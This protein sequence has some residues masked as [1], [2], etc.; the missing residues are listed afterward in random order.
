[1][2]HITITGDLGSGKSAVSRLLAQQLGCTVISTGAIQRTIAA[3]HGMTTLELNKYTET[4]PEIDDLIDSRIK[5]LADS[6][7]LYVIDSRLAWFFLPDSFKVY[8]TVHAEVAVERVLGDAARKQTEAY[9]SRTA[10]IADLSERKRRENIRFLNYY[11]ADCTNLSLFDIVVDTSL[12]T[13]HEVATRVV[14]GYL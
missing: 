1:M 8:L 6:P 14:E 3:E 7:E 5:A 4:H 11:G 12:L 2:K 9:T 10:A 13:P